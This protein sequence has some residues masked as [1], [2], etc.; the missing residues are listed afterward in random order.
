MP[1]SDLVQLPALMD[2]I[3]ALQPASILD[4]G[5][6]FGRY[7]FLCR[8]L[9][10]D[11]TASDGSGGFRREPWR[12][13]LVGVEVCPHVLGPWHQQL[14][15]RIEVAEASA[16]LRATRD[17]EFDLVL[18]IDLLEHLPKR[19]AVDLCHQA[20]RV[21]Q[22]SLFCT[23]YLFRPQEATEQNPRERHLSGWLPDDFAALGARYIFS[24]GISLVAVATATELP[25]PRQ[26]ERVPPA[27]GRYL[28]LAR[29]LFATYAQTSQWPEAA[30]TAALYLRH[31]P[32]DV[33]VLCLAGFVQE[34]L[35]AE[36][37]AE[38]FYRRA[39]KADPDG[40]KARSCLERL[41]RRKG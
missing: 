3:E 14:Y 18:A 39:I 41:T 12:L 13:R 23:P 28:G 32:A 24:V 4:L 7:G 11:H 6:G 9:L 21:G 22:N 31:R 16:F 27:N 35:G 1:T 5:V 15:D 33:D 34:Q 17:G 38:S 19:A 25:L 2:I 10:D 20:M 36:A 8:E 30:E 29:A 37:K 26:P 40:T